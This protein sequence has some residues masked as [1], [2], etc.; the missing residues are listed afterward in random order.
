V[1]W[2]KLHTDLSQN[3]RRQRKN[4]VATEIWFR[5]L[6]TAALIREL[7]VAEPSGEANISSAS[8]YI[9]SRIMKIEV[10]ETAIGLCPDVD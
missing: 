2:S 3:I 9:S 6:C 8:Q 5:N 10:S 1:A 7:H 4:L